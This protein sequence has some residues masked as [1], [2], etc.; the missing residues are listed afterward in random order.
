M[1]FV[2]T[3]KVALSI[4]LGAVVGTAYGDEGNVSAWQKIDVAAGV[5]Q[6]TDGNGV[7]RQIAPSCSGGPVCK[8]DA[9]TGQTSCREG[10]KQFSF[11]F[12]PGK[13]HK[14]LVFFDGGGCV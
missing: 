9:V 11:Y 1:S 13:E 14:L 12:K 2:R 7:Q 3:L 8:V 5:Y 4:F 10:N 6:V